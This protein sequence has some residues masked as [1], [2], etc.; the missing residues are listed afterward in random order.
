MA[1]SPVRAATNP[2]APGRTGAFAA[3]R[4]PNFRWLLLGSTIANGAQWIQQVTLSWMVYDLTASGALL[5]SLSLVGAVATLGVTPLAGVAIDRLPR[6]MLLLATSGWLAVISAV[7]GVSL[8][9][10]HSA[11]WPL[12]VFIFLAGMAQAVDMPVRQAVVFV[13]VPRPLAPAAV[14]LIQTGWAIM[15]SLGPAIGGFLI[16]WLGPAGNFLIQASAYALICLAVVQIRFPA[17]QRDRGGGSAFQHLRESLRF[18]AKEPVTRAFL[19]IGMVL[20]LFIIPIFAT[21]PPIYAKD[22][23]Q[24]G[25]QVLGALLSAV[26]IGGIGGGL[27]TTLLGRFE[28]RGIL[29]LAALM[30]LGLTLIGFALCAEIWLALLALALAG[31]FEMVLIIT[32]QTLLQLAIPDEL[33]GRITSLSTL[34]MGLVPVGGLIA[35]A[36]ADLVGPQTMTLLLAGSAT[37][38]AAVVLLASPTIRDYRLSRALATGPGTSPEANDHQA[39]ALERDGDG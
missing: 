1:H 33:R 14:A 26:G 16:L 10:G 11:L 20:P 37:A 8:L 13:L 36:G 32:N 3:L 35:G 22:V 31:F 12:F 25:P 7:L 27:V 2:A 28:R 34:N 29:L 4:V 19:L 21:L 17:A 30:L 23:F 39:S 5:G 24:G 18:V 6:G 15:R 38:I 9:A